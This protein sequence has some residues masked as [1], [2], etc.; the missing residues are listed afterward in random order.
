M[1]KIIFCLVVFLLSNLI[2]KAT[3][4]LDI[5]T[6]KVYKIETV[7]GSNFFGKIKEIDSL[8]I[9][10]SLTTDDKLTI[11]RKNIV[12]LSEIS[13]ENIVDGV[14]RFPN[15]NPHVYFLTSSAIEMKKGEAYYQNTY[16]FLNSFRV[17]LSDNFNIG[18]GFELLSLISARDPLLWLTPK[19][20]FEISD[21]I[22]GSSSLLF[23]KLPSSQYSLFGIW[24]V[25]A[26]FGNKENNLSVGMGFGFVDSDFNTN[27]AITISGMTR[28][29]RKLMF[30]SENFLTYER[31]FIYLMFYGLRIL[32]ET[33]A[34][35]IGFAF[36]HEVASTLLIG[37]PY[38]NFIFKL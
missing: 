28:L 31:E 35:D 30:V 29:S 37:M 5:D 14:Y 19:Y 3:T 23:L 38:I 9:E 10:I 36:N 2:V 6:S 17:A 33:M 13:I 32:G 4:N 24:S 16:V 18:A 20:D 34:F 26:T 11:N 12:K 22:R 27:P 7:D 1:I 21:G 15:P 25:G 8:I